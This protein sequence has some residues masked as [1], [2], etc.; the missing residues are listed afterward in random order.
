MQ[1]FQCLTVGVWQNGAAGHYV[2]L[3]SLCDLWR[4]RHEPWPFGDH[5]LGKE[6]QEKSLCRHVSVFSHMPYS[7]L[8]SFLQQNI[9][10]DLFLFSF[11]P[12]KY[13]QCQKDVV[14]IIC[15]RHSSQKTLI[16]NIKCVNVMGILR[17]SRACALQITNYWESLTKGPAA[18]LKFIITFCDWRHQGHSG[19]PFVETWTPL[20]T[21]FG[22]RTPWWSCWTFLRFTTVQGA[23]C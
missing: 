15:M 1:L 9:A 14:A 3:L 13:Q 4:V 11:S 7:T 19:S 21:A 2:F 12:E 16:L 10:R 17:M 6:K 18:I 23:T 20:T 8:Y 5:Y 22:S